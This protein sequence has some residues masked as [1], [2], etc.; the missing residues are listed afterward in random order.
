MPTNQVEVM[1]SHR[2]EQMLRS[3]YKPLLLMMWLALVTTALNYWRAWDQLPARVAVHF[4]ANWRPNGFTSKE[5]SVELGLGIMAV[6]LVLFT[7]AG[8]IAHAM[9]PVAAW[10]MLVVFYVV[11]G[12]VWYGN[13]SIVKFNLNS[14]P[15]HSEL[16]GPISPAVSDSDR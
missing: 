11:L 12:F 15:A 7:V 13:Y 6:L 14:Q 2:E 3:G 9:K 10:P 1:R 4:D 5:G 8:L 16:V